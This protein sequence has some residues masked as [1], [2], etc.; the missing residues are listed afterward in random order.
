[1]GKALHKSKTDQNNRYKSENRR[2]T[3]KQRRM[4]RTAKRQPNND[5]VRLTVDQRKEFDK[6]NTTNNAEQRRVNKLRWSDGFGAVLRK[7]KNFHDAVR[8]L[9]GKLD[10]RHLHHQHIKTEKKDK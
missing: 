10:I 9:P 4:E 1:M 5:Q 8:H 3:N 2:L 7:H 6:Q